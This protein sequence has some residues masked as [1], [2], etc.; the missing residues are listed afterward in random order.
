MPHRQ[1]SRTGIVMSTSDKMA[2]STAFYIA[3]RMIALYLIEAIRL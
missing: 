3:P 2:E 1:S